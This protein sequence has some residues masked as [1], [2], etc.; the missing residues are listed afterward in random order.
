MSDAA[1]RA[2]A[3][4]TPA[5]LAELAGAA[6]RA[7]GRVLARMV[8]EERDVRTKT[9][10]A[11]LVSD[12]DL[13]A[14]EAVAERLAAA[15]PHDELVGEEALARAGTSGV[16]WLIDPLDGT[17]NFLRGIPHWCV[18]VGCEDAEGPLAG[19]ICDPLRDELFVAGR[20]AGASLN[21]A[22]LRAPA[23]PP[24]LDEALVT[25]G[26]SVEGTAALRPLI[27]HL[28]KLGSAALDLAWVA[29]GRCDAFCQDDEYAPWDVAAGRVIC[30]EAGCAVVEG[31]GTRLIVGAPGLVREI[32]AALG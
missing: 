10:A 28:R 2:P 17:A 23:D 16:R 6:A 12:A 21:G 15:R 13:A 22:P 3:A 32:A 24:P 31:P 19:G 27:G 20:G 14:Q 9:S 18:S 26:L 29:C 8:G 7:G 30:A 11:D 4:P 5:T 25:G 1:A